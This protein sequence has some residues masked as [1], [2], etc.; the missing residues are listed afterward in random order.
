M[1]VVAASLVHLAV[2]QADVRGYV[3]DRARTER[4]EARLN[5]AE[6]RGIVFSPRWGDSA[7]I[8]Y[9]LLR[10]D[11]P[12]PD[13][14]LAHNPGV[15]D[16]KRYLAEGREFNLINERRTVSRGRP[17]YIIG[18]DLTAEIVAEGFTSES[19]A[20]EMFRIEKR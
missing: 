12:W 9:H 20:E 8:W 2:T 4:A 10:P 13:V 19:V 16:I 14:M 17:V 18:R 15:S 1:L 3:R 7:F 6:P 11:T 5:A